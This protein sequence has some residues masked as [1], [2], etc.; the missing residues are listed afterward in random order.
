MHPICLNK[1]HVICYTRRGANKTSLTIEDSLYIPYKSIYIVQPSMFN[2]CCGERRWHQSYF[3]KASHFLYWTYQ[4]ASLDYEVFRQKYLHTVHF[5]SLS[6]VLNSPDD[7]FFFF[8]FFK[9]Y[10]HN[11]FIFLSKTNF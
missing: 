11:V 1:T 7:S 5:P 10:F 8:F 9:L 6:V 4:T 3:I 2:P